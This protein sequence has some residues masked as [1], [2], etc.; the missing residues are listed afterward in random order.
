MVT[1]FSVKTNPSTSNETM[2][3][4]MKTLLALM[5][6]VMTFS[7]CDSNDA[8]N[9]ETPNVKP[10]VEGIRTFKAFTENDGATRATIA[11]MSVKWQE[12]DQILV[13]ADNDNYGCYS[14]TDGAGSTSGTFEADGDEVSGSTIYAVYPYDFDLHYLDFDEALYIAM[15]DYGV[16]EE[17]ASRALNGETLTRNQ[18][19]EWND[20]GAA[21]DLGIKAYLDSEPIAAPGYPVEGNTIK[22]LYV[23]YN[24][25]V[26]SGEMVSSDGVLMAA[27][28]DEANNLAFKNVCSY[29]KVTTTTP[30]HEIK[31]IANNGEYISGKFGVDF[32]SETPATTAVY[33][34]SG[35]D[36]IY[37]SAQSGDLAPGT[38]YIAVVPGT[39]A[40]GL[41][42]EYYTDSS[43]HIDKSTS[44]SFTFVRNMVHDA[45]DQPTAAPAAQWTMYTTYQDWINPTYSSNMTSLYIR[46]EQSAPDGDD[47]T[48]V[49]LNGEHTLWS[50][51]DAGTTTAYIETNK[52]V[53]VATSLSE[54]F[55]S[56]TRLTSISGLD[57]IDVSNVSDFGSCFSAARFT[58]L[59][60][61]QWQIQNGAYTNQMF[62]GMISLEELRI[63][64]TFPAGNG[65]F[66]LAGQY[67]YM[68]GPC[69]VYGASA[70]LKSADDTTDR[71]ADRMV[72]AD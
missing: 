33:D 1:L 7:A 36:Y 64:N 3:K 47:A 28:A 59:D 14:L 31:V 46:T 8:L 15:N 56:F 44:S 35:T 45:G 37:F 25:W 21:D 24:Q 17:T 38:Y 66:L 34:V 68:G 4:T 52:S 9:I 11:G 41:T 30:L 58:S 5:A 53:I 13:I 71:E 22:G 16:S 43:N 12:N 48:V 69:Q 39:L 67:D 40:G 50:R 6:G 60:L 18:R 27:K 2:K 63:N 51:Y 72:W 42:I 26:R 65:M 20:S 57:K 32:S 23:P 29:I 55:R 10:E 62:R 49:Y 70:D 19:N 54:T 61:S